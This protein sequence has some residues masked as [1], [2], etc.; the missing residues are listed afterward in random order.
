MNP[1]YLEL[2]L[3]IVYEIPQRLSDVDSWHGLMPIALA[4]IEWHKPR[5]F[6]ELGTHKGDSYCTFCQAVDRLGLS[7]ACYAV[8]TWQGE[9]HAGFYDQSVLEEL[10]TFHDARY[11]RFSR[12]LQC[13]F[14]DA[15]ACFD[16]GSVDLLH[17]DG[18]HTYEAVRHDFETW[19][20]KL[21]HRGVVMFHDIAVRGGGFGVWKLWGELSAKYPALEFRF[22]HGL[23][24][25]AVGPELDGSMRALFALTP[26][27]QER[28]SQ[29]FYVL[30]H[31]V[32]L[33]GQKNRLAQ[34]YAC[35]EQ[36]IREQ[37]NAI[38]ARDELVAEKDRHI[39]ELAIRYEELARQQEALRQSYENLGRQY[40][41]LQ[42]KHA[43][44]E[45]RHREELKQNQDEFSR[46]LERSSLSYEERVQ[47]LSRLCSVLAEQSEN[48]KQRCRAL[49]ANGSDLRSSTS[50]QI[51][52][53]L[54][55]LSR[56][57]GW[58]VRT[59]RR[60]IFLGARYAYRH[61]LPV[62]EYQKQALRSILISRGALLRSPESFI[63]HPVEKEA[64]R[65]KARDAMR[66]FLDS[67]EALS[68]PRVG[69]GMVPEVS[70]IIVLY[71]QAGLTLE[72]LRALGQCRDVS[73]ETIV[74]DNASTDETPLLMERVSGI[75]LIRNEENLHFLKAVN[76]GANHATGKYLLLLNN[77]ARP[78]PEALG[79][80]VRRLESRPGVG[81]VG[82]KIVLD[83]GALQ[84][85]GSIIWR[86]GSCVGYGRGK[87]PNDAPYQFV[88]S[89]DYCSGVFLLTPRS[90]FEQFGRL[91]EEFAPAYYE[92]TDYCVRLIEAGYEILYDPAVVVRHFEF[93][94]SA[95]SESAFALQRRNQRR[96]VEKH[97]A[98]LADQSQPSAEHVL[99]ARQRLKPGC[100]RILVI[101]DR[102]PHDYLGSGYPR[103]NLIIRLLAEQGHAVTF[104]PLRSPQEEW[105]K[106][107]ECLPDTVEAM[108][109]RGVFRLR[110]FLDERRGHYDTILVSRPH[111]MKCLRSLL[112]TSPGLLRGKQGA[113]PRLIYDA[114]AVVT[115]REQIKAELH[116]HPMAS[117]AAQTQ[118]QEEL[119]LA[120]TADTVFAVSEAEAR[121]FR[122]AGCRNVLVLGHSLEI[123]PT[124][125]SFSERSRFL[126]VGAMHE[127]DSPN[128]DSILWFARQVWPLIRASLGA[129][130]ELDIVGSCEVES[131]RQWAGNGIR[132]HGAADSLDSVFERARVFIVPT[133]YAAGIP[134][135]AHEAASRG[136][137][138][139]VTPL[140][141]EQLGWEREVLSGGS[142]EAFAEHCL[143]LFRDESVW[144][145]QREK[146]LELGQR[147]CSPTRFRSALF[148]AL[149]PQSPTQASASAIRES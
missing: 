6:V 54:R 12:L 69:E 15:L 92:E 42:A 7:T 25:L 35:A 50:W 123:R 21:S 84:E 62:S 66:R 96:F 103:A 31:R 78:A 104:Y 118:L 51:T 111:N 3:P 48:L 98:F 132:I 114:E 145:K 83:D 28:L 5:V 141:A 137:P 124:R 77:D 22:S 46:Q 37:S 82:G 138:M 81:A 57:A 71:N 110:D 149:N 9:E 95:T 19:L 20:P 13:T 101:D 140:I 63:A 59:G 148:N 45:E 27:E 136:V 47:E 38:A 41:A 94:S 43:A 10:R 73:L 97:A 130:A 116:G 80:A 26:A 67:G 109:D 55:A 135:K 127:E 139:V 90:L 147:D 34:A 129:E 115:L 131:V 144:M 24:I 120:V 53:P 17:I 99:A 142:P 60:A 112:D 146:V 75:R 93:A 29:Y 11:S 2:P 79:R 61:W 87:A 126:F 32:L 85:A 23:G 128:V 108:L 88:R 119:S 125:N 64:V 143:T 16:D 100:Q 105:A 76:Q 133:R 30:G 102:V 122:D 91:D 89:V 106:V 117:D 74:V 86:D 39:A 44:S 121:Y 65:A 4:V 70:V 33:S 1:D 40:D 36:M 107:Y 49:E 56:G 18:L 134:H 8:D 14:D 68:L 113:G 72:C 58:L 52:R